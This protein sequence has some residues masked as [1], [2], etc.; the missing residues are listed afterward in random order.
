MKLSHFNYILFALG[1]VAVYLISGSWW[2]VFWTFI[3]SLHFTVKGATDVQLVPYVALAW[4]EC[5]MRRMNRR[6]NERY[7]NIPLNGEEVI[8]TLDDGTKFETRTRSEAWLM[9]GHTWV[10]QIDG[11][12]GCYDLKRVQRKVKR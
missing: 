2:V 7:R 3:A 9:G 4:K 1:E 10:V 6:E 11:R 5:L 8:V 12:A